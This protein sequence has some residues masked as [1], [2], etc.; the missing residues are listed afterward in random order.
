MT[1]LLL[2]LTLCGFV[3]LTNG[4]TSENLK[5]QLP[6]GSNL[7]GRYLT[8]DSGRGIR[9]FLGVPYAEAPIGEL[10][11]KVSDFIACDHLSNFV[12]I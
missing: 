1:R 9:A 8:S 7:V 12:M 4:R 6:D 10:R 3:L 2:L 11:F 5:V